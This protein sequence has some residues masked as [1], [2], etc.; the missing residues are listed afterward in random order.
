MTQVVIVEH[1]LNV[2]SS[3]NDWRTP[4]SVRLLRTRAI[5]KALDLFHV[6]LQLA[7]PY[8]L[9]NMTPTKDERA[10]AAK[11]LG[12]LVRR[13]KKYRYPDPNHNDSVGSGLKGPCTAVHLDLTSWLMKRETAVQSAEAWRNVVAKHIATIGLPEAALSVG[14]PM[15]SA[16]FKAHMQLGEDAELKQAQLDIARDRG[17]CERLKQHYT[18]TAEN[19]L[20]PAQQFALFKRSQCA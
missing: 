14:V 5:R 19:G 1:T 11:S 17:T 13:Y 20:T 3:A 2:L 9:F 16:P 12:G 7:A 4:P 6:E 18:P 15:H 10:E 8:Q